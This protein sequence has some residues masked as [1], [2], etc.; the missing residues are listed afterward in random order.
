V[1][2]YNPVV[3]RRLLV[4][5]L[6]AAA[7]AAIL[8]WR[9]APQTDPRRDGGRERTARLRRELEQARERLREDLARTRGKP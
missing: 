2:S 4:L 8:S 3:P 6:G 7:V 9:R 5:A 1:P